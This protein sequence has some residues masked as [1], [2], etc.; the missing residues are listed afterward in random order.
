MTKKRVLDDI[1]YREDGSIREP[2]YNY[3]DDGNRISI[4]QKIHY[5]PP[6]KVK[7]IW[8]SYDGEK[9]DENY[10]GDV[11]SFMFQVEAEGIH[12]ALVRSVEFPKIAYDSNE[13]YLVKITVEELED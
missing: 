4:K 5:L 3:D 6:N 11:K 13:D 12:S 8:F 2:L 7:I 9:I 1:F 10:D